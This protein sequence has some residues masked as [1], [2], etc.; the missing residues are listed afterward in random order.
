MP[1]RLRL[2][3]GYSGSGSVASTKL[4]V[5]PFQCRYE[6][7]SPPSLNGP[8]GFIYFTPR[9]YLR[10]RRTIRIGERKKDSYQFGFFFLF[11][12]RSEKL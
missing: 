1:N 5:S 12:I 3:S 9:S 2:Q 11:L 4:L 8:G 7:T 10:M 6:K